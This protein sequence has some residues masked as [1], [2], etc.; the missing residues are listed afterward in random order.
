MGGKVFG[1]EILRKNIDFDA[2]MLCPH[3]F[4]CSKKI[5]DFYQVSNQLTGPSG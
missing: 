3:S 4:I 1:R 2:R 5:E